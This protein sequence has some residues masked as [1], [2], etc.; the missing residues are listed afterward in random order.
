VKKG[1]QNILL[2]LGGVTIAF[3]L[4]EVFLRTVRPQ[5]F[6]VHPPGMYSQN[7]EIGYVP[8][9]DFIGEIVHSEFRMTFNTNSS[10]L[11]G[12][13]LRPRL[14]NTYRILVLGDSQAWGF[15][16]AD[17]ETMSALLE[18]LLSERYPHLDIQVINCGVPGYGTA[19]QLAFL[20]ARGSLLQPDMVIVQFFSVNDL[21]ENRTPAR[22]WAT[23]ENGFLA[24]RY[25]PNAEGTSI[26]S[27]IERSR[28]WLKSNSH[29]ARLVMDV[30]GYL[31]TR[32]GVLQ[33]VDALWGEDF[34]QEEAELGVKL[35]VQ[36]AEAA[37]KIGANTLFLY[38]TGQAHVIQDL[39]VPP[40]SLKVVENAAKEANVIWID[41]ARWLNQNPDK[42]SLYFPKNGHWTSLGHAAMAEL[43]AETITE[44][45]LIEPKLDN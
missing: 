7:L 40:K 11:R 15:G 14:D 9:P 17:D 26:N 24:S 3:L 16:V 25:T 23:I 42:Y 1:F 18:K 29:L 32:A 2:I 33:D 6:D 28:R 34:S 43:L 45:Y 39:Y 19:D 27:I 30:G 5:I 22:E 4:T 21:S 31:G 44:Q 8:T 35:L 20:Q 36:V 41:S 10:G 37:Q 12:E 13:E 38:T